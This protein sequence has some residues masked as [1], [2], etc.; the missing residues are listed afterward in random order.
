M[1]DPRA[2]CPTNRGEPMHEETLQVLPAAILC[3]S[4]QGPYRPNLDGDL[5][6]FRLAVQTGITGGEP[7]RVFR[8]QGIARARR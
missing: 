1:M 8:S 2:L 3:C 7:R 6:V 4:F 5:G